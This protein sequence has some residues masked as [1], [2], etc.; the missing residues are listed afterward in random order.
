MSGIKIGVLGVLG[1]G[2]AIGLSMIRT[3][4]G[5]DM[6]PSIT[7]GDWVLLVPSS[8]IQPGEVVA[9]RDP[10]DPER[11]VLRRVLAIGGQSITIAEGQIR[12]DKRRLRAAAMG[13]MGR[14]LVVRETLWAKRPAVGSSWL[15]R[16]MAEPSSHWT[17]EPVGV[18][19]GHVYLM[20]D[21]RD[22]PLDSRW[23]GTIPMTSIDGVVKA[24]LG[25][26]HTWRPRFEFLAG[27]PP[28]GT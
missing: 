17:A 3:V 19:D 23:W 16:S 20:A 11:T 28:L 26:A 21:D 15:T 14:H 9:T 4:M 27:T 6:S 25:P 12:V 13:D 18:P 7:S 8:E 5:E 10:L 24:R 22:G 1:L 2:L